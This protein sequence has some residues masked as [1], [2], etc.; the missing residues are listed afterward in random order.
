MGG[1][2]G[3]PQPPPAPN[4]P[5]DQADRPTERLNEVGLEA[6]S[7]AASG[8]QDLGP[9]M[10]PAERHRGLIKS[11]HQIRPKAGTKSPVNLG[12]HLQN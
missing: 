12:R 6:A 2:I 7:R 8:E 1:A 3:M 5:T 9:I 4:M 11:R 10:K